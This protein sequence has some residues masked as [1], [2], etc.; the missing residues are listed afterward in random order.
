MKIK[1]ASIIFCIVLSLMAQHARVIVDETNES[2]LYGVTVKVLKF[3]ENV[4]PVPALVE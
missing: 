4:T 2:F 1:K 3:F